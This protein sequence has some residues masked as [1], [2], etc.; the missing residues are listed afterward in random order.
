MTI[1]TATNWIGRAGMGVVYAGLFIVVA[2]GG[3]G[4]IVQSL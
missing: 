2:V 3:L 4:S 1:P